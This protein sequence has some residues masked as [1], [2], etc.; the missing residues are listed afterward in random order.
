MLATKLS[1]GLLISIV[2]E[3]ASSSVRIN[4]APS[5][6]GAEQLSKEK[7]RIYIY[8]ISIQFTKSEAKCR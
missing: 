7:P 1:V 8:T 6:S 2:L 5:L 4:D 3:A